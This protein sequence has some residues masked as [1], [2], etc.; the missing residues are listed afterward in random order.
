M[1]VVLPYTDDI[2]IKSVVMTFSDQ[3]I[4]RDVRYL[5]VFRDR[6]YIALALIRLSEEIFLKTKEL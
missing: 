4:Y 5:R 2:G 6:H 3:P 1:M